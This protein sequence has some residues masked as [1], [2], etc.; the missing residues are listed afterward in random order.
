MQQQSFWQNKSSREKHF[1]WQGEK[2]LKKKQTQEIELG[3]REDG[4]KINTYVQE[5]SDIEMKLSKRMS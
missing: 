1:T 4:E 3:E 2:R 5:W